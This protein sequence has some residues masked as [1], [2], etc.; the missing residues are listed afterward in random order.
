[1][2]EAGADE[3]ISELIDGDQ[4]FAIGQAVVALNRE[5][6]VRPLARPIVEKTMQVHL[7]SFPFRYT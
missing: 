4:S 7:L 3:G 2:L 6:A 5:L 1:M